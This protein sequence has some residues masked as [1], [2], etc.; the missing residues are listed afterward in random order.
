MAGLAA[1]SKSP[2]YNASFV[3][4]TDNSLR[5][6]GRRDPG[7]CRPARDAAGPPLMPNA[8]SVVEKRH[9]DLKMPSDRLG[10]RQ[11]DGRQAAAVNY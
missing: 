9:D 8:T 6:L 2:G 7:R 3:P 11:E 4:L 1:G 10:Q 5:S